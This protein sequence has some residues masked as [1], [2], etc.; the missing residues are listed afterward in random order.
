MSPFV[1]VPQTPYKNSTSDITL[2]QQNFPVFSLHPN[3]TYFD[4]A[5]TCL[6][7]KIVADAMHHYQCFEHANSH[8]GLYPLSANATEIVENSR[9]KVASFIGSANPQEIIFTSSTTQ[10]INQ[11]AQ[12]YVKQQ[13]EKL[14]K[15][16]RVANII[17]SAAEHHA[18]FLPWQVLAKTLN[19][20][21]RIIQLTSSGTLDLTFIAG[22]LDENSVLVAVNHVSNV[23]GT[24][25]PINR[26]CQLAHECSVPVLVDGAQAVGHLNVDIKDLDCDFYAFSGHKMYGPTGIGILWAKP[27]YLTQMQPLILGGGIVAKTTITEHH[28]LP[29]P[30]KFEAGSH[31]VAAIVGLTTAIDYLT[32]ITVETKQQHYE[33]LSSYLLDKMKSLTYVKPL[34]THTF[35]HKMTTIFSFTMVGVHSHD[36]ASFLAEQGIAVR[37]GHHCAEP[38]HQA[39]NVKSSVRVSLGHYNSCSDID[40]L[41]EALQQVNDLLSVKEE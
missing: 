30:L 28:L 33:E 23:L 18:N 8:K 15:Q 4:S 3:L 13:I 31:N 7:P 14:A 10:A 17:V 20:E 21:L 27:Y 26:I 32:A 24:I 29:A 2:G 19:A 1:V 12:G 39:L 16:K 11:V 38:L 25:N 6:T 34:I 35:N 9:K 22:L 37:A 40:R 36:V 5:A 41:V